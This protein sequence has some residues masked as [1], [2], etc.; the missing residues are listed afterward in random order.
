MISKDKA[1][2]IVR[3]IIIAHIHG[4]WSDIAQAEVFS[5][6]DK[7]LLTINQEICTAINAFPTKEVKH[8]KWLDTLI[9]WRCSVCGKEQDYAAHFKYCI[10]CGAKMDD[11]E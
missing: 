4:E 5:K 8:G 7:E 2:G 3:R 1:K 9:G 6:W 11:E 10:N